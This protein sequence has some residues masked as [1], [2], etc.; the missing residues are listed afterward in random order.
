MVA[1][2]QSMNRYQLKNLLKENEEAYQKLKE[3][4]IETIS[5]P[6]INDVKLSIQSILN[7]SFDL[8]AKL[9]TCEKL[10]YIIR[11]ECKDK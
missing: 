2:K 4:C 5:N 7:N 10:V 6:T 9:S 8:D 11:E 3:K 1:E